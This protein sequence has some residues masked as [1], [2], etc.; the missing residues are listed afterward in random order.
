MCLQCHQFLHL[1]Y[2][3][4]ESILCVLR[5]SKKGKSFAINVDTILLRMNKIFYVFVRVYGLDRMLIQWG[6]QMDR[7]K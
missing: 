5:Q 3:S 7:S 2:L 6:S 1:C 4:Q